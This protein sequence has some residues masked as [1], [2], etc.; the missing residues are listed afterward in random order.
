MDREELSEATPAPRVLRVAAQVLRVAATAEIEGDLF[1]GM[2][3]LLVERAGYAFAWVGLARDDP[4]QSVEPVAHAGDHADYLAST[5]ICWSDT[6]LGRGPTGRAVRTNEPVAFN[7]SVNHPDYR[8][9]SDAARARG[10]RA[11]AAFPITDGDGVVGALNVYSLVESAFD[12]GEMEL[13]G[14]IAA[15]LSLGVARTRK[16]AER[17]RANH[18]LALAHAQ[19]S[20]IYR[21]SPDM[22]LLYSGDG[23]ILQINDNV[24]RFLGIELEELREV[25]PER[26]MGEGHTFEEAIAHIQHAMTHG[27]DDFAWVGRTL[28]GSL[29]PCEVRLRRLPG[30]RSSIDEPHVV[31]ITRDLTELTRLQDELVAVQRLESLAVLAGGIAHDFNNLLAGIIGNVELVRADASSST[32]TKELLDQACNAALRARGLTR[33]LLAFA[34]GGD[35]KPVRFDLRELVREVATFVFAGASVEH[36]LRLPEEPALILADREQLG[37]VVDN[38]LRNAL[39]ASTAGGHVHVDVTLGGGLSGIVTLEVRD[40]GRGVDPSIASHIF[41]PFFTTKEAGTGLGLSSAYG[42]ARRAGGQLE[43]LSTEGPGATFRLTLPTTET[44]ESSPPPAS[45]DEPAVAKASGDGLRRALVM[46]DQ[47]ELRRLFS[48]MLV[49]GGFEVVSCETGEQALT[50]AREADAPFSLALLDL[51]VPGGRGGHEILTELRA[52]QPGVRVVAAT[53]YAVADARA[54]DFDGFLAKP[55]GIAALE[56]ELTRLFPER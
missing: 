1:D 54:A 29:F 9:W 24:R 5:Q 15:A 31:S 34:R 42:V 26:L 38:L 36:Q 53:G 12:S 52:L 14:D 48:R 45:N 10:F 2:C 56:A 46:D 27:A 6:P 30:E 35:G 19:L 13:L 37:Q 32:E 33:Q 17:R 3:E 16:A 8:P 40:E 49:R 43:L 51:T 4:D 39:E 25:P 18:E 22:I 20:A 7:L 50:H 23:R 44:A 11:S 41:E 47:A 21:A 55:F 28:D